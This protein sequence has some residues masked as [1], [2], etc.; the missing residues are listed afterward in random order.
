[1]MAPTGWR[2]RHGGRAPEASEAPEGDRRQIFSDFLS[3]QFLYAVAGGTGGTETF[4]NI[5]YILYS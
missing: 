4:F 3:L 5:L 1:M 2:T